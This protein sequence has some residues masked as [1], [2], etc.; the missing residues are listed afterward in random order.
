MRTV[1]S[2]NHA[3]I[4]AALVA[5][6]ATSAYGETV[7]VATAACQRI[8]AMAPTGAA[9]YVPGRDVTG[10]PVV[11][12]DLDAVSMTL[13]SVIDIEIGLDLADR[14]GLRDQLPTSSAGAASDTK[15]EHRALLP[16]TGQARLGT[17]TVSGRDV[18]WNGQALTTGDIVA[19]GEACR[20]ALPTG[21]NGSR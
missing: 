11:P 5:S 14:I 3:I 21:D 12:A 10:K 1:K 13:P 16:F 8:V 6:T 17:L 2:V 15:S 9:D 20:A 18:L 4:A 19:F 7:T